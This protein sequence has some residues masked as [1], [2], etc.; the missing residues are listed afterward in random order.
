MRSQHL[1]VG[2]RL[3]SHCRTSTPGGCHRYT[4]INSSRD[5]HANVHLSTA[6]VT[7]FLLAA[8]GGTTSGGDSIQTA[9]PEGTAGGDESAGYE[10]ERTASSSEIADLDDALLTADALP[11]GA[12]ITPVEMSVFSASGSLVQMMEDIAFDP[13]EC[14]DSATYPLTREGAEAVGQTVTVESGIE[15]DVLTNAVYAGEDYIDRCGEVSVSGT[16]AVRP[17]T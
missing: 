1:E 7:A 5:I 14:G 16:G 8:C 17:W 9:T 3:Y 11:E 4:D 15:V 13:A 12:Q 2:W 6:V 10:D